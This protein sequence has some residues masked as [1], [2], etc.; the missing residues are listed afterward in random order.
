MTPAYWVRQRSRL[1]SSLLSSA[2]ASAADAAPS[3]DARPESASAAAAP[4]AMEI[5]QRAATP[6]PMGA[7]YQTW[8]LPDMVTRAWSKLGVEGHSR[9]SM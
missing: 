8:R 6:T 9:E 4:S 7:D 3:A 2:S 1:R 5:N